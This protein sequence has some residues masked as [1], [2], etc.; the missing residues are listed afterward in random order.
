M[1]MRVFRVDDDHPLT[2]WHFLAIMCFC[3]GVIIAV[4]MVMAFIATGT[5]P[6]LVVENS[7]V[8]S[9][10]YDELLA[11]AR[12]QDRKG[13]QPRLFADG[14]ALN[15]V[16]ADSLGQRVAAL[17][18][19][20]HVGRPATTRED[21]TIDFTPLADGS[22]R[23]QDTLPPGIWEVD[24]EARQRNALVFRQTQEIFVKSAEPQS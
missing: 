2:G 14:G 20:A 15:F 13:W 10:H 3:F 22:Y 12:E 24:L 23:A 18:V 9:Q 19:S 1:T 5:F 4:N 8:S 16:L 11:K 6:G 7:Y 21:R 17:A